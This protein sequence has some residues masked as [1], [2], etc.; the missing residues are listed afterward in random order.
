MKFNFAIL[1]L[2]LVLV[3]GWIVGLGCYPFVAWSTIN[4]RHQDIDIN[5]GR[6]RH[7]RYLVGICVSEHIED[8]SISRQLQLSETAPDWRRV[9]TFSPLVGHS[10]H[11]IFH[12]G[13]AQTRKLEMIWQLAA[14][15]PAAK[16]RAS[17]EVLRL[18]QTGQHDDAADD[19]IDALSSLAIE[20]DS[21][22]SPLTIEDLPES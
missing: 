3:A 8:S 21:S 9:N 17:R 18:W 16:K 11:Y 5:T 7:Q 19:F 22:A 20:R 14:F 12:S 10:P 1:C 4:C 6:I 2:L 13:I 15:T